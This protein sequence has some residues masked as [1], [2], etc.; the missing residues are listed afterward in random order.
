MASCT[1]R[2]VWLRGARRRGTR[3][4]CREGCERDG[5][6]WGHACRA[7][8]AWGWERA[9]WG[10]RVLGWGCTEPG[11]GGDL[12]SAAASSL[13]LASPPEPGAL[14]TFAVSRHRKHLLLR[15]LGPV[16]SHLAA[17]SCRALL[18]LPWPFPCSHR[19]PRLLSRPP[20]STPG[21]WD[22]GGA[23]RPIPRAQPAVP[24]ASLQ[25]RRWR[26]GRAIDGANA[27]IG[28]FSSRRLSDNEFLI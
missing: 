27:I 23:A 9:G 13:F 26:R 5:C 19:D 2:H 25:E 3:A 16:L 28:T 4:R 10:C 18:A 6:A 7:G 12:P 1:G 24:P 20:P 14:L 11:H 17:G 15:R 8:G 22:P 21:C